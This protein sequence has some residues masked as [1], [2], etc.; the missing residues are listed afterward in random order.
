MKIKLL[1]ITLFI[2]VSIKAQSCEEVL[3]FVKSSGYGITYY[4]Y[5]STAISQ[6]T[7]YDIYENYKT[8]YFAIVR[9]NNSYKEYVYQVG[10]N[11][12]Y[13]YSI[14]YLDSAGEAFWNFIQPHNKN[15]GCAPNFERN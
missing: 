7:F 14:N 2:T 6:V 15:L 12:K 13:N 11:T 9:F 1:F 3:K 4:S 10:S 5:S 8:Y